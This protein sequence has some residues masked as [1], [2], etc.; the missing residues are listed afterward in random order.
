MTGWSFVNE[1][2]HDYPQKGMWDGVVAM[3]N[4][5]LRHEDSLWPQDERLQIVSGVNLLDIQQDIEAGL[6]KDVKDIEAITHVYYLGEPDSSA[7]RAMLTRVQ[8]I[9]P[10][11][12]LSKNS[13]ML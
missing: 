4:R 8:R 3:T 10:R 5:P 6:K 12:T 7:T 11:P 1:L 2:L 9:R 13:R